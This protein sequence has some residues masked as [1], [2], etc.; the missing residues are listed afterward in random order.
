MVE[1]KYK[2]IKLITCDID[3]TLMNTNRLLSEKFVEIVKDLK[4]LGVQFTFASG[5]LPYKIM[6]LVSQINS[7]LPFVACNGGCIFQNEKFLLKKMFS[8][9]ILREVINLSEILDD[10]ILYSFD[11]IE[12]CLR[13]TKE[14]AIKRQKR[15]SYYPIRGIENEEWEKLKILKLNILSNKSISLLK[16]QLDAIKDEVEITY[17]GDFGVEIVP[18]G[19][20]KLTGIKQIIEHMNVSLDEIIAIGDNEN[21]LELLR[22][23]GIGVAVQNATQ[24]IK[25]CSNFVTENCGE[26]GVIEFLEILRNYLKG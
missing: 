19:V 6:P 17:Y 20:N 25:E 18:K 26:E 12:Y 8:I 13:E 22:N 1:D 4:D 7:D 10:T 21:D 3:G 9:R 16:N 14:S 11:G 2:K 24:E 5:R 23:V 15:G